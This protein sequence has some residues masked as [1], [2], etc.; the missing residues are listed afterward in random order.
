MDIFCR[1]HAHGDIPQNLYSFTLLAY[2]QQ[3]IENIRPNALENPF[4]SLRLSRPLR[5]K[6]HPCARS[7]HYRLHDR[8]IN[9]LCVRGIGTTEGNAL[10]HTNIFNNSICSP[11]HISVHFPS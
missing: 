9:N 7:A 10:Q 8:R 6:Y 4:H 3:N 11:N 2:D 5:C 1:Y